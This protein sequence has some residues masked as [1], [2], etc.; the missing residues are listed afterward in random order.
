M[1]MTFQYDKRS[2]LEDGNRIGLHWTIYFDTFLEMWEF[3]Y[4]DA[5]RR[6]NLAAIRGSYG[7]PGDDKMGYK[8]HSHNWHKPYSVVLETTRDPMEDMR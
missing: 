4:K 3:L 7:S 5:V 2:L 6:D 1:T 8:V